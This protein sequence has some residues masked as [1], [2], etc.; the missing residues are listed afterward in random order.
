MSSTAE[1]LASPEQ[2]AA[3]DDRRALS[4]IFMAGFSTQTEVT[5]D[6]GRGVGMDV[7]RAKVQELGGKISISTVAGKFLR[8][9]VWPPAASEAQAA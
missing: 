9:R 2:A 1:T 3:L 8:F 6:A 7:V 4:L 5:E